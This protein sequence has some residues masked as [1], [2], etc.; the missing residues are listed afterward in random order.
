MRKEIVLLIIGMSI[1][2]LLPRMF[3]IGT[4]SR[5]EFPERVKEWLSYIPAAVLGSLLAM[6]VLV[7]NKTIDFSLQN[8]YVLAFIPT[9]AVAVFTRNLFYTLATGIG[10][11]A[12]INHLL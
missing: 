4:L 11:M 5:F 9:F 2:S 12:V 10:C 7:R 8:H 1:V 6:S 3:P